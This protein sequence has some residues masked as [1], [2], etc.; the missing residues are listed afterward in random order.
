MVRIKFLLKDGGK[1]KRFFPGL[2]LL[3]F[4]CGA[5]NRVREEE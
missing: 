3:G 5:V 4:T 1:L 2:F